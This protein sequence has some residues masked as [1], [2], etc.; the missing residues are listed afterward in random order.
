MALLYAVGA[1]GTQSTISNANWGDHAT[2]HSALGS[3][4]A[5]DSN[6][7]ALGTI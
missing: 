2:E 4:V 7:A 1:A 5:R 6:V 3:Y